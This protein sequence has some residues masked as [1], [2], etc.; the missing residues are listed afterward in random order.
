MKYHRDN[1]YLLKFC[2][3]E[4]ILCNVKILSP[5][6]KFY[7]QKYDLVRRNYWGECTVF[8]T[9]I[10]RHLSYSPWNVEIQNT[11]AILNTKMKKPEEPF[12]DFFRIDIQPN[13][14]LFGMNSLNK[15]VLMGQNNIIVKHIMNASISTGSSD[16]KSFTRDEIKEFVRIDD[17]TLIFRLPLE[18][19]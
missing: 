9:T 12:Q 19:R 16:F 11:D 7:G 17:P 13:D 15:I 4:K 5:N 1:D 8:N 14:L 3:F 6:S 10:N 2:T 18:G